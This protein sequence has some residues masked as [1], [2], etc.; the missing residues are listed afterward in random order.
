ME[1]ADLLTLV[2]ENFNEIPYIS[3]INVKRKSMESFNSELVKLLA[4]GNNRPG[5]IPVKNKDYTLIYNTVAHMLEDKNMLVFVEA[6]KS[7]E[8]LSLLIGP[9][10]YLKASKVKSW[11]SLLAGKYSETKTPV[12]AAVDK[13]MLAV[14][15]HAYN[16][17]QFSTECI[18]QIASTHKNPRVK[19]F[20][21]E[22][23]ML[24]FIQSLSGKNELVGNI[25]RVIKDKLVNMILKDNS[26][27]CRDAAVTLLVTFKMQIGDNALVEQA[28]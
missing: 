1:A 4:L 3:Q 25:F 19:Q 23:T 10:S 5:A 17:V 18:N 9:L 21:V 6:I 8:L 24:P 14:V 2:P 28:I 26:A 11:I 20:V 16:Q 12:I 7:V 13:A 15:H 22:H 27:S